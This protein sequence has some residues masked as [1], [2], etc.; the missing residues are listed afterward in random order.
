V[1]WYVNDCVR[2]HGTREKMLIA[3]G[4]NPFLGIAYMAVGSVS[5]VLVR[6]CAHANCRDIG[7]VALGLCVF[8]QTDCRATQARRHRL[9]ALALSGAPKG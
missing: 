7:A 4:K 8:G 5:I 6:A 1:A 9:P 2:D 3:G